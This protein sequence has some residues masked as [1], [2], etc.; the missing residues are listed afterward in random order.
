MITT[1]GGGS[2]DKQKIKRNKLA[3]KR[4]NVINGDLDITMYEMYYERNKSVIEIAS[5]CGYSTEAVYRRIKKVKS[6]IDTNQY[7]FD[8]ASLKYYA[9]QHTILGGYESR[10]VFLITQMAIAM[11]KK[12]NTNSIEQYYYRVLEEDTPSIKNRKRELEN[13]LLEVCWWNI[14]TDEKIRIFESVCLK[15]NSIYFTLNFEVEFW[16]NLIKFNERLKQA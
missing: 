12:Y 3:Y 11:Y 7:E 10:I 6:F 16:L 4:N 15:R 8:V 1:Q 2:L 5:E 13:E 14:E 9:P